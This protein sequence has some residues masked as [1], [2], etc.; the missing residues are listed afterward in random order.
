[1]YDEI[2]IN[3]LMLDGINTSKV[4]TEFPTWLSTFVLFNYFFFGLYFPLI[5]LNQFTH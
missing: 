2:V 5:C 1:M 4:F 3:V